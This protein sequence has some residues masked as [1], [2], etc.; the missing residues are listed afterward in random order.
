MFKY[1]Y[2]LDNNEKEGKGEAKNRQQYVLYLTE[3]PNLTAATEA[4]TFY[5]SAHFINQGKVSRKTIG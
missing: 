3:L 1:L 4:I 5:L 2:L